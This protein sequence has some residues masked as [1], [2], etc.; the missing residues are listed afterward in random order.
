MVV[1]SGIGF[2]TSTFVE[3]TVL[4]DAIFSGKKRIINTKAPEKID[5][6]NIERRELPDL[7]SLYLFH[8]TSPTFHTLTLTS[9]QETFIYK[10]FSTI[11]LRSDTLA[12]LDI[13]IPVSVHIT[14]EES[15][16]SFSHDSF[17]VPVVIFDKTLMLT[18][19]YK[20]EKNE[21]ITTNEENGNLVINGIVQR[22]KNV[23]SEIMLTLPN[24]DVEKYSF[25]TESIDTDGY[26]KREKVFTKTIPLK[27]T[28]LHLVELNY[29]SGFA[30]YNGPIISGDFL[31]IYPNDSDG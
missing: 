5:K 4:D 9:E 12:S 11:A 22:G 3:I 27:Q 16:T 6:L 24:G 21:N 10:G 26:L 13:H 30:A 17:T 23:K 19:G 8:F 2:N 7:T 31:P 29:D 25:G 28:G 1:A 20:E 14:S 18:P 15:S